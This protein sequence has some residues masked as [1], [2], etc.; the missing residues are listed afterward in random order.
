MQIDKI[1]AAKHQLDTAIDLFFLD[2]DPVSIRTLLSSAWNV[3]HDLLAKT[4]LESS[5]DWITQ[6]FPDHCPNTVGSIFGLLQY[7][8]I[9]S[10]SR[11]FVKKLLIKERWLTN[12]IKIID[13]MGYVG[14]AFDSN[15]QE[16]A[17]GVYSQA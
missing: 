3:L 1:T 4:D 8:Y 7:P 15:Q 9:R 17:A 5:R 11:L 13:K 2:R 10:Y 16:P 12:T 14:F 6:S